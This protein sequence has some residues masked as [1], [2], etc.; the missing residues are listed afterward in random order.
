[1]V[2]MLIAIGSHFILPAI[3]GG[4]D[5][6]K[7]ENFARRLEYSMQ[8][9]AQQAIYSGT[10]VGMAVH[11][12]EL[13]Y[14]MLEKGR[15]KPVEANPYLQPVK[16][17]ARWTLHFADV[18]SGGNAVADETLRPN[19]LLLPDGGTS[20][21]TLTLGSRYDDSRIALQSSGT[22]SVDIVYPERPER[23]D[24]QHVL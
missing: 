22:G 17:P 16:A 4:N 21:F 9:A 8:L 18:S 3:D 19:A 10:P 6:A 5:T 20:L 12:T 11:E 13:I 2:I 23:S 15:W 7:M 1:M 24:R 14:L